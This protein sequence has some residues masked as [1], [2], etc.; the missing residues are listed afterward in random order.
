MEQRLNFGEWL[1]DQPGMAGA[2]QDA[3]GV[4]AQ[5]VGYGPFPGEMDYSQNASE[6]L[7]AV[8]TGKFGST[9]NIFAGGNSKLFKFDSSDLSMDDVSQAGGYTGTQ[10]WKF[11]QFG[12]VVLAANGAEKVQA[13]TLGVSTTF[14]DLAAA[15]PIASFVTVVRDFVVCANILTFP[16]RVQWSDINDETDWTAGAAS[17]SDSQDMPDGGNIVGITGGE[18]GIVL[19][20][21]AIV[22]MSY[23]GAP[24]FFQFDTISKA[25][26][27]YDAGSVA[28]YGPLTFFL[29]DDGF[30]VCDGQSVKPI[31]AEKVDRWFFD[32]LDPANVNKMSAA[33][34]PIRKVVAWSYPNTRAGQSILI[35][36]WQIQ[37]WTYADTTADFISSMATS[38]VTLEGLD[39]YSASLDALDTSLD[40]RLWAGGRF[41]FAGLS[42]AKIVTFAGDAVAAN[43]E[44]GDFVAGQNSVVKLARPQV[45]NGSAAVAVASRDRLDDPISFGASTAADSDNRVSLRSFGKYHRIRVVPSG[46]WTT[47]VGVDVDTTQAGGR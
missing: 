3:K 33:V 42:D 40:S 9:A 37:R 21:R 35:Y 27:C 6:N 25:L 46:T 41:V 34:D 30:Y 45:D 19:L 18:F 36:N 31:G 2:L 16:N 38:A 15:A 44:T 12:K 23:I 11:A 17:Q 22:R 43:I 29:S 47:I 39:L 28:Q 10:P 1:P 7:T 14:A 32:D 13:W 20:E 8:F 5:T 24:F 26:G 4:V